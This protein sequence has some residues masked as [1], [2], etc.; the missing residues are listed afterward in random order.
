MPNLTQPAPASVPGLKLP[1]VQSGP[2]GSPHQAAIAAGNASATRQ[3][4]ANSLLSGGKRYKK[5]RG[6]AIPV[7][8]FH[9]NYSPQG[10]SDQNPNAI[11]AS[12]AATSTQG[13]A[14]AKYDQSA[15]TKGGYRVKRGGR[16]TAKRSSYKRKSRKN[17]SKRRHSRK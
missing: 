5:F 13:A 8:Q 17:K 7:P 12:G 6:G 4:T 3:A 9:M 11:I 14:N 16:R 1:T 15:F 2:P 10:G